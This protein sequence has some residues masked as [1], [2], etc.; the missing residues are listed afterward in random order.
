[1]PWLPLLARTGRAVEARAAIAEAE[2]IMGG[3]G[4]I[5]QPVWRA[6]TAG[7]TEI[8]VEGWRSARGRD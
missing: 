8:L 7:L 4:W 1:M 2:R 5:E 6:F 3:F